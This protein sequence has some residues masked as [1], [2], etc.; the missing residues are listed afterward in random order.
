MGKVTRYPIEFR[1]EA[2]RLVHGGRKINDVAD[3]LGVK[4]ETVRYWVNRAKEEGTSTLKADERAELLA[5][6]KENRRLK[7]ERDI[8]KKAAAFFASEGNRIGK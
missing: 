1:Q 8:L 2:V 6:R 5:L 3:S 4:R 7:D